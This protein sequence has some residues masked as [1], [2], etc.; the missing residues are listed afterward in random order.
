MGET[1]RKAQS[2]D[3]LSSLQKVNGHSLVRMQ[4]RNVQPSIGMP[5]Q[6]SAHGLS[7]IVTTSIV[8]TGLMVVASSDA[9]P[10]TSLIRAT[11]AAV[12]S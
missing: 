11:D 6:S 12:S 8:R 10:G 7:L 1:A 2:F 3:T 9:R 4:S 5:S